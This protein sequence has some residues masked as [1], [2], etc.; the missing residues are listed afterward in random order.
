MT[1]KA[2]L[3]KRIYLRLMWPIWRLKARVLYALTGDC[4]MGCSYEEPYGFVP[5]A[6]CPIHDE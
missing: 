3:L 5:E 2:P 1:W 4:G 6:G